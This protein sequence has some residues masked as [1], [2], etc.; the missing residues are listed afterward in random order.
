[1]NDIFISNPDRLDGHVVNAEQSL[2][3]FLPKLIVIIAGL[4]IVVDGALSQAEIAITGG[5]L[6]FV[7]RS[8]Y[9]LVLGLVSMLLLKGRFQSSPLLP[10]ALVLLSYATVEVCFLHFFRD[11]SFS[12][13]RRSF[14]YFFLLLIVGVAS[15]VPLNIKSRHLL[16]AVLVITFACLVLSTAQFSANLPIVATESADHAFQVE[17]YE[18]YGKIR[19]FSFFGSALQAGI[20][21]CFM[22]GV[23]TSFSLRPGR[24][25]FGLF[26][27]PLCAFG[28]YVTYTRLVMVGF[29]L[30]VIAVFVLS[31]KGLARFSPLLPLLSLGCAVLLV[32]QGIRTAGAGRNDL[33]NS[34]SLDQRVLNWGVYSKRFL[35]G[36]P[37]DIL[38]GTG[39]GPYAPYTM[40]DRPEN[41]AP[42]P[43][44][45]AYLLILL[46][47]GACGLVLLGVVYW[48]FWKF[49]HDRA[50]SKTDCLFNGIAA[51]FATFPLF[52][53]I[54]DPPTQIIVFLL[55][56]VSLDSEDDV[57]VAS[58]HAII[59]EQYLKPA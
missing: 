15:V 28:C 29:I 32:A 42:V 55:F 43:V 20:F 36:S 47:T 14:E 8:H 40:P 50:T 4:T 56:A 10:L 54:S 31:R 38:F 48:R 34:S 6:L 53:A 21:Y 57:M 23:A 35:A 25:N 2:I 12:S 18:F 41:A 7:P 27:L 17:S 59:S 3:T 51:M 13:I 33:A 46:S 52:C 16:T 45:N 37:V 1:M 9:L 49:L 22:G 24:R 11:L 39:L 58:S 19:A 5:S 26:L 44:D 30:T